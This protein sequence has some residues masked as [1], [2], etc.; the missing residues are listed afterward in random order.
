MRTY[1]GRIERGK[2][3]RVVFRG[4]LLREAVTLPRGAARD[5]RFLQL[6]ILFPYCVPRGDARLR[7]PPP[8]VQ[9]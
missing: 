9:A 3:E 1:G 4:F 6:R 8:P 7:A 2:R 5:L